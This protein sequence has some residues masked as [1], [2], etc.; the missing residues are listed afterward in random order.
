MRTNEV[1]AMYRPI[2]FWERW[3]RKLLGRKSAYTLYKVNIKE[4]E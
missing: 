1:V 2:P 4:A 3:L